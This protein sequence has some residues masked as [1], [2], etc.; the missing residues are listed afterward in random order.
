MYQYLL[1]DYRLVYILVAVW[2]KLTSISNSTVFLHTVLDPLK[3][4]WLDFSN[5]KQILARIQL[6]E[7]D[8]GGSFFLDIICGKQK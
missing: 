3:Q 6:L 2:D 4:S 7:I 5:T 1:Y 8:C